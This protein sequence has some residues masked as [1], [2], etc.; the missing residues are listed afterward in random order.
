M[1]YNMASLNINLTLKITF[2]MNL[3]DSSKKENNICCD[4]RASNPDISKVLI[5]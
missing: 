1:M 3:M 2:R 4:Y 5:N